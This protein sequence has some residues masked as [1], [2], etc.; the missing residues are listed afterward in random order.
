MPQFFFCRG[1][2]VVV[3]VVCRKSYP[4]YKEG[5]D[6]DDDDASVEM[7]DADADADVN[8]STE[9]EESGYQ[10]VLPSGDY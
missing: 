9:A 4:D 5:A 8:S 2:C 7:N 6:D 10:L 3:N 1:I